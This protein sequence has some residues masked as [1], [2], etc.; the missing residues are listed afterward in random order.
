MKFMD[1]SL[2]IIVALALTAAADE[3]KNSAQP[4]PLATPVP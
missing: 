3:P 4:V 2:I 1:I